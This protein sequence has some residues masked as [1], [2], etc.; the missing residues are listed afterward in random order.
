MFLIVTQFHSF[1]LNGISTYQPQTARTS[2]ALTFTRQNL[3]NTQC[4]LFEA[5]ILFNKSKED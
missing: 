1:Q 5:N 2:C 3:L 4:L